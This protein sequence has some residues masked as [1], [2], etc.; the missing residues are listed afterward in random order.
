MTAGTPS[1][2]SR[3]W[4]ARLW[5]EMVRRALRLLAFPLYRIRVS[6]LENLPQSGGALLLANHQSHLDPP[7]IGMMIPRPISYV[8]RETLFRNRAFGAFM[9]S[10]GAFPLDRE[11][12]GIGGLKE[13]LRRLRRGEI[14]LLFPEGT[15]SRDG[16]LQ[17]LKPGFSALA[18]R[19]DVPIVVLGIDGTYA[20]LPRDAKLPRPARLA[21][22]F[23]PPI[24]PAAARQLD[25]RAL[26]AEVERQLRDC[27]AEAR[28]ARGASVADR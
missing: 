2:S 3:P 25:D 20:A 17:P 21:L 12:T 18:Q 7:L 14:V 4:Y 13:T 6:G 23:A 26:V 1:P 11:G 24:S 10:V 16:E 28:R 8:A 15:R 5:Y 9:R 22:R 19:A 27:H